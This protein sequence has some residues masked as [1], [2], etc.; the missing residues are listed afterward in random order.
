[1]NIIITMAGESRRFRQEGFLRPKYELVVKN[2]TMFEWALLS[3]S[4]WFSEAN[5]VFVARGGAASFIREKCERL[6]IQS[7]Q[8][9]ELNYQTMGQ[10]STAKIAIQTLCQ[11]E[12]LAIY[13]I[14]THIHERR[15]EPNLIPENCAGWIP[16][17]LAPGPHWSF[18][19]M[20]ESRRIYRVIEKE[21]ISEWATVGFYYFL[22]A[23]LFLDCFSETYG[24]NSDDVVG[25]TY[26]APLYNAMIQNWGEVFGEP[27]AFEEVVPLGTPAEVSRFDPDFYEVN[28]K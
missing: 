17:F 2:R 27:L 19:E 24:V 22:S 12:P 23:S 15:L 5:F 4:A 7:F 1:M 6:G 3:L 16:V 21:R 26:V 28:A 9:L 18:A 8:V 10:A 11:N 20:D 13:N 14:D 25:E